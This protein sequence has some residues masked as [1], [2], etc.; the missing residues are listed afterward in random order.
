MSGTE[1]KTGTK[2]LVISDSHGGNGNLRYA[3][4]QELPIDL[5]L[6]CGD[7]QGDLRK[8]LGKNPPYPIACVRGNTDT[9]SMPPSLTL[10]IEGHRIFVSH[11]HAFGVH[12]GTERILQ[13]A[14]EQG[15][16]VVCFGHTHIPV[17]EEQDGVL[18]LNPGSISLPRTAAR[19]KT[20]AVLIL[21]RGK[22]P[23]AQIKTIPD[24][25]PARWG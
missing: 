16:D 22:A 2:I 17:C 10:D 19:K 7:V 24:R 13:A 3:I 18:L 15:C 21:E 23:Q 6:H 11:G 25:I 14:K 9:G 4:G 20:Y 1:E 8:I 12:F 5:L